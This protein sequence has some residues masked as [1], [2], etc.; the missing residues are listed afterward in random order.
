MIGPRSARENATAGRSWVPAAPLGSGDF[1]I[2]TPLNHFFAWN[3]RTGRR[4]RRYRIA[5]DL[6]GLITGIGGDHTGRQAAV[7][8]L[9]VAPVILARRG[10]RLLIAV[11][12]R[13]DDANLPAVAAAQ[14]LVQTLMASIGS[15]DNDTHAAVFA[16]F[17][18]LADDVD[19][20]SLGRRRPQLTRSPRRPGPRRILVIRLSAL[21]DFVQ[22][23]GPAAAIRRHHDGDQITL[24]TTSALAG[25]AARVSFFDEVMIDRRPGPF[26]IMGWLGL[27][28]RLRQGGF[29]RVYDLQTSERTAAYMP[30]FRPGPMPEWSGAAGGC[31]HPHANLDRDRQH[32]IDKQAEQL[33]MAG[34]HPTPLP[35]LPS[36]DCALPQSLLGRPF[37]LIVPG[38]SPR[39][40]EKRWPAWRFGMLAV[41][42]HDLGYV[43]VVIGS[44]AEL[45]LAAA[46]SE[47]CPEA[48]DLVGRTDIET[49]A[50]LA[51]RAALTIGNDTGVSHLAAAAGCP[52]VVLF[53]RASDPAWCAP[54]G[55][56]VRV[57][58]AANLDELE[59]DRVLAE[60][61]GIIDQQTTPA[62]GG[63]PEATA[64]QKRRSGAWD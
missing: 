63:R 18:R 57:L 8:H 45:D 30:L 17:E 49:V 24:L 47:I 14:Q 34:I 28:R 37:I 59:V 20:T 38:S 19:L 40:P 26:D 32:T 35:M 39:H 15:S 44:S 54:R 16:A 53:S 21:G 51:Q 23:L 29:D 60:A 13:A 7:T 52:I 3:E 33:L 48:I 36:L 12:F 27:R 31:S 10:E 42:L 46:I 22:A 11:D 58:A 9:A 1:P 55:R 2:G 25:F 41:G 56:V 43:P 6:Y 64:N 50:G 4:D 5:C 62:E 61:A